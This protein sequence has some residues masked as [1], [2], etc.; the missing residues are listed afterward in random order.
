MSLEASSP[1]F[2]RDDGLLRRYD[3]VVAVKAEKD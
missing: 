3:V 1:L 2:V